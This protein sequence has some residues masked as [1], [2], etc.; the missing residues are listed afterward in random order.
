MPTAPPVET[1]NT[2]PSG[3][4]KPADSPI[5]IY[6]HSSAHLLAPRVTELFP[7][8]QC[9]TWRPALSGRPVAGRSAHRRRFLL[10]LPGQDAVHAGGPGRHRE[11]DGAHREAE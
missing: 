5:E 3:E 2:G 7:A 4:T 9:G 11:E 6:R 1:D 8:A 10:R